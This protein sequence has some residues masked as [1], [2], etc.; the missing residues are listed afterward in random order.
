MADHE[1]SDAKQIAP[2]IIL[3]AMEFGGHFDQN[4]SEK[5]TEEFLN[6][7]YNEID[8]AFIYKYKEGAHSE[9]IIGEMERK[10]SLSNKALV[11]T[12]VHP[13]GH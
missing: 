2:K 13:R 10:W 11:S 9:S 6:R 8:T 7:G 3:G 4:G 5:V 1:Q 12:K